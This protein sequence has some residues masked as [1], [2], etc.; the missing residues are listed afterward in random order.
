MSTLTEKVERLRKTSEFMFEVGNLDLGCQLREAA[1]IIEYLNE[2]LYV[3]EDP[4]STENIG[5]M[6]EFHQAMKDCET[7]HDTGEERVFCCSECGFGF[8][9]VY[10]SDEDYLLDDDGEQIEPWPPFCPNCGRK[11]VR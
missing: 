2:R 4:R 5:R 10:L 11:V 6:L 8:S 9:D 1:N 3:A 7:C